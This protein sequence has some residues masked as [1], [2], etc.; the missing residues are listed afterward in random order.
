MPQMWNGYDKGI[1]F[2]DRKFIAILLAGM[3]EKKLKPLEKGIVFPSEKRSV[4]LL[5]VWDMK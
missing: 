5:S 1:G 4:R 2:S 3:N